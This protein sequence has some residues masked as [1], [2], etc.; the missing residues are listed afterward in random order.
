VDRS[1]WDTNDGTKEDGTPWYD[2]E[3]YDWKGLHKETRLD[4]DGY[5]KDGNDKWGVHKSVKPIDKVDMYDSTLIK[6][7]G[8]AHFATG[9]ARSMLAQNADAVYNQFNGIKEQWNAEGKSIPSFMETIIQTCN[10]EKMPIFPTTGSHILGRPLANISEYIAAMIYAQPEGERDNF[11]LIMDAFR[12]RAYVDARAISGGNPSIAELEQL[13]TALTAAGIQLNHASHYDFLKDTF[14]PGQ[15]EILN[16]SPKLV[17]TVLNQITTKENAYASIDDIR[18]LGLNATMPDAG[19]DNQDVP[20]R[21]LSYV[22]TVVSNYEA[23]Y[24]QNKTQNLAN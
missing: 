11:R 20:I 14:I 15:A 23:Q 12:T 1:P 9:W 7:Q 17:Q 24:N 10:K 8:N 3:D 16:I 5:D 19:V 6:N 4:R 18:A 2:N 22:R 21:N 13:Y